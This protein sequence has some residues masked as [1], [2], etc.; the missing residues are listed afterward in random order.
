MALPDA[1]WPS[2]SGN[3]V[4]SAPLQTNQ[5]AAVTHPAFAVS[6]EVD[7]DEVLPAATAISLL[8]ARLTITSRHSA[9]S[10]IAIERW[11]R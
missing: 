7:R 9:M 10:S 6:F 5:F 11:D 3:H 4:V 8:I 1:E 2:A